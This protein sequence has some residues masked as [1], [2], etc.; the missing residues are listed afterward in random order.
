[1]RRNPAL[2]RAVTSALVAAGLVTATAAGAQDDAPPSDPLAG[3]KACQGLADGAARLACFDRESAAMIAAT[4]AGDLRLVDAEAMKSTKR[5]LFGFAL[6]RIGL[7]GGGKGDEEM[8]MMESTVTSVN[9][10]RSDAF[11][12]R[13]AEGDA[14]WQVSNAP[15]RLREVEVGDKVVFKKAAMGSYFI[16]IDGQTGIKGRRIQ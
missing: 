5:R 16:R 14:T 3:L 15:M 12:F 6:P 7:F 11:T 13:I 8:D 9:Y 10:Q 4:E 1:M 2:R